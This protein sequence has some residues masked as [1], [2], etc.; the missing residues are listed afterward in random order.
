[1][2][3]EI[4]G[5]K[6]MPDAARH[7]LPAEIASFIGRDAEIAELQ[8]LM[9][10]TR[11]LTLTGPGGAGKT[12]LALRVAGNLVRTFSDGVWFVPLATVSDSA[13]VPRTIATA[14]GVH[15]APGR[16]VLAGLIAALGT[17]RLL[18][19]LDN[20][21]HLIGASARAAETL[22]SS[23]PHLHILATSREPL[24]IPGEV[25]WRVPSLAIPGP[26]GAGS[27]AALADVESVA[28]FLERARA[29][30]PDFALT[31][32]NV[33]AVATICRRLEGMPLAVEL[34]A[35]Q[36]GALN[37]AAI[38]ERLDDALQLLGS[39]NRTV[40]RQETL[41]A[42][43][44]WSHTLLGADEQTLFRRLAVF[45]GG[46]GVQAAEQ[47]CS[48]DGIDESAILTLL[49]SLV[50]KSLVE[51]HLREPETRYRLLE[52]VRQYAWSRL[53]E[54]GELEQVRRRHALSFADLA[55]AADP[56]L[57][58]RE[59]RRW[60]DRLA[61]DLGNLR[62]ALSW[63]LRS[64]LQADAET[65]LRLAGALLWFWNFRG[66][67]NEG[68]EWV[69]AFLARAPEASPAT[70][71]RALYGAA[72]LAWLLGFTDLARERIEESE[73]LWR[74]LG[75]KRGLAYTLQSLPMVIDRPRSR[76]SAEESVR[77]FEEVGDSF[78]AAL[79]MAAMDIFAMIRD[80]D[81]EGT[82]RARQEEA[83]ARARAVGD[84]W[85][86]A[87]VLNTLGDLD[88][89]QGKDAD[90]DGHYREALALLRRQGMT[91]T[92][93]SILHNLA[94]VALRQGEA[95][96]ALRLFRESLALFR[97][98]GD[99][100]GMADCLDGLAGALAALG[101]AE[102]AARLLG[103][104]EKLREMIG[105]AVWPT[106]EPDRERALALARRQLDAATFDRA[107]AEGHARP[108][109]ETVTE[110]LSPG[111][112]VPP[113]E[114][115]SELTP[116]EREVAALV[117]QGLTNRQIGA[118]LVITEGTARLHVKHIL[119][120]LGFRSRAQIAAWAVE[121]GLSESSQNP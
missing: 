27:P 6:A 39:G 73:A 23:C 30:R 111:T 52:P 69:E 55:D 17:R 66:E 100:R 22:L 26:D 68:F 75:D 116:R 112:H 109:E 47:V 107:R 36:L 65:G 121:R 49:R 97:D 87:Q 12:R 71:A 95:R 102:R 63:C 38:A 61:L 50:E 67:I 98:Q 83:L 18:L 62:A 53:E 3:R 104:A 72:E 90:A 2:Q 105:A 114:D 117:A 48:V 82:G 84:D 9:V 28:L 33:S 94:A 24:R 34:A 59:R 44:D 85:G 76:Q 86:A 74:A 115:G 101:H 25:T 15:G 106:N 113:E 56:H 64:P 11:L 7:N 58:S 91:G 70:R 96:Q 5:S 35:A 8:R 57:M 42:T 10:R 1:M 51:M 21:E 60:L 54:V 119:Q 80:G 20:C 29:R 19:V 16:P 88:R 14:L 99:Q 89:R 37:A 120:K 46:F 79:A 32:E 108:L 92:V 103:A 43:L 13:L 77:L 31:A 93:P 40:P 118:A 41:Q 78:G 45:S 81:P 4:L 110:L